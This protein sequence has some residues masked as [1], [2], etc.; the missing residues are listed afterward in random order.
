MGR[1]PDYGARVMNDEPK[2]VPSPELKQITDKISYLESIVRIGFSG[3]DDWREKQSYIR[4]L[5]TLRKKLKA[6]EEKSIKEHEIALLDWRLWK[7]E[8]EQNK[9]RIE[10]SQKIWE[11]NPIMGMEV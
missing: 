7:I 3:N 6:V 2:Y 4:Q 1:K 11:E 8:E 5:D 9:R 10:E